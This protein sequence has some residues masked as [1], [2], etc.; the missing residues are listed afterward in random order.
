MSDA[1]GGSPPAPL[2][3][4]A[5]AVRTRMAAPHRLLTR[6]RHPHSAHLRSAVRACNAAEV[7][8]RFVLGDSPVDGQEQADAEDREK[9]EVCVLLD[10]HGVP[11][12]SSMAA[13]VGGSHR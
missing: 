8:A 1:L 9:C 7:D 4:L 5:L 12:L 6:V 2:V 3:H 13:L 11:S 10:I